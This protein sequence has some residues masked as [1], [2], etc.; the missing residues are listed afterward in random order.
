M[1]RSV[2]KIFIVFSFSTDPLIGENNL[3]FFAYYPYA[4]GAIHI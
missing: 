3:S 1:L 2:I 4:Y